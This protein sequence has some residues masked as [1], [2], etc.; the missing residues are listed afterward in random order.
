VIFDQMDQ[1]RSEEERRNRPHFQAELLPAGKGLSGLRTEYKR[2][3]LA[4][5][6]LVALVLLITCTNVGSLLMV[7]NTGRIR[8]LTVRVTL[9][10]RRSRLIVQSLVE[11]AVLAVLGGALG[12]LFAR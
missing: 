11:S 5:T 4:L 3:L 2:P 12:L 1:E 6:V 7:R 8:E 10:A 9:G